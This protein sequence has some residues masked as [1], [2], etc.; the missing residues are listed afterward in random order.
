MNDESDSSSPEKINGFIR[1]VKGNEG[2]FRKR[3]R[4]EGVEQG[5]TAQGFAKAGD[6]GPAKDY[7]GFS[8]K[9]EEA[10]FAYVID[11]ALWGKLDDEI[12]ALV[13]GGYPDSAVL[14]SHTNRFTNQVDKLH[15]RDGER[16]P[17]VLPDTGVRFDRT[18]FLLDRRV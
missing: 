16:A 4:A 6:F 2:S 12:T 15:P 9:S 7:L 5:T 1:S 13:G 10:T 8:A 3:L 18:E 14:L 11:K 17:H